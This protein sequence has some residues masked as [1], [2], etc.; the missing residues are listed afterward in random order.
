MTDTWP[1]LLEVVTSPAVLVVATLVGAIVAGLAVMRILKA[2]WSHLARHTRVEW[3]DQKLY[4]V[5]R[6][7]P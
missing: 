7:V 4:P 1:S 5:T 6:S 2:I 3:D